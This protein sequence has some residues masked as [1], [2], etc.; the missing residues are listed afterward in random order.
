MFERSVQRRAAVLTPAV[1]ACALLVASPARATPF[2]DVPRDDR[3]Y[4][5]LQVLQA[6]GLVVGY[7]DGEFKGDRPLTRYELAAV[8]ARVVARVQAQGAQNVSRTDLAKVQQLIDAF[9]DELDAQGVRLGDLEDRVDRLDAHTK[10]AQS[11]EFHGRFLPNASFR[12][13]TVV[14]YALSNGTGAPLTSYLGAT[15]PPGARTGIDPL[16]LAYLATDETNRPFENAPI[17]QLRQRSDFTLTYHAPGG[18]IVALPVRILDYGG[19]G[20]FGNDRAYDVEPSLEI[21]VP[22]SGVL[23]NV[24]LR[25]G[26][27][28]DLHG[29]ALGLAFR[30]PLGDEREPYQYPE[31]PYQRGASVAATIFGLTDVEASFSRVDRTYLNTQPNAVLDPNGVQGAVGYFLPIVPKQSGYVQTGAAQQTETFR[32]G[33][34]PLAQVFLSKKALA[35][36]VAVLSFDGGAPPGFTYNDAFNSVVFSTPLPPGTAIVLAYA[37]QSVVANT[38]Y[39]RYLGHLRVDQRIAGFPGAKLGLTYNRLYDDDV[40]YAAADLADPALAPASGEGPVTDSVLGLD[41]TLPLPFR[42]GGERPAFFG[43][44][45]NSAFTPD[46]RS[47]AGTIGNASILGLR[48][49]LGR[50][51]TTIAYRDVAPNFLSGAPY[52]YFGNAPALLAN[53]S[54]PYV[55]GFFGFAN[56]LA[57]NG[58]FDGAIAATGRTSTTAANP[59]L[60]FVSPIFNPFDA[61]GPTFFSAYAPNARGLDV[62]FAS[63]IRVGPVTLD[64][65]ASYRRLAE[66]VPQPYGSLSY[67]PTVPT[68]ER[69]RDERYGAEARLSVPTRL[70]PIAIELSTAYESL[71]RPD[72]TLA[73]YVPVDLATGAASTVAAAAAARAGRVAYAPN[74]LAV[75]R[76]DYTAGIVVP[77][78]PDLRLD[79][80][81]ATQ[82]YGGAAGTLTQS[83]SEHKDVY[84]GGFTYAIPGTTSSVAVRNRTYRY[85]DDVVPAADFTQSRQDLDFVVKF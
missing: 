78:A 38:S 13:R 8:V 53:Y 70:A 79:V 48:V 61:S 18:T 75:R 68:G 62:S 16:D 2:A 66:I 54:G 84:T 33:A 35:G 28:R 17:T 49:P 1:F 11:L 52:R 37:A 57:I 40:R 67:A 76:Y 36:T 21:T 73:A 65:T 60:T 77:V 56:D 15:L 45:A 20:A 22:K 63:P 59:N 3:A 31:Q 82:R 46:S 69:M 6:D 27:L 32:A 10:L 39:P 81:Y 25:F 41:F 64:A 44:V 26:E 14:P 30:P 23:S 43:E 80:R 9:K 72:P 7:P 85:V 47:V 24:R 74:Y 42:L 50:T 83:L 51:T 29:S 4:Q 55:P 71:S 19:G 5:D 12:Q 58:R 34:T